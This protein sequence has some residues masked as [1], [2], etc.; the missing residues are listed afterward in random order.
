MASF[1][2]RTK[3]LTAKLR[4]LL[5]IKE[6]VAFNKA[7]GEMRPELQAWMP[8]FKQQ[9]PSPELTAALEDYAA[10]LTEVSVR[11]A[12]SSHGAIGAARKYTRRYCKKTP[13]RRMGFTQK[14]SCRPYK[15]CYKSTGS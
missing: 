6:F 13:C 12:P 15:N 1:L 9:A 4:Q 14:A 8:E 10:A 5:E 3:S 11:K 2:D 7:F